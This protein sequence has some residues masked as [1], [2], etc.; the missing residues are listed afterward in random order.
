MMENGMSHESYPEH[1]DIETASEEYASRFSGSVGRFFLDV[2]T[3]IILGLLKDFSGASVL[4]VG[5]GHAQL[6]VPL[7]ENGFQVTVTGSDDICRSRLDKMLPADSF[8][9]QTCD[10]LHLPFADR[11]F[12]IVVAV[13]LLPHVE[14]WQLLLA[15]MCRVAERS[16]IVD[17]PDRRSV[18]ILYDLLFDMKK[19]MEGNTRTF[20]M[21]SR[22][23]LTMEFSK[24]DFRHPLFRPEFFIPM[25]VHRKLKIPAVSTGMEF[26]CRLTGLTRFL[27]SPI[28]LRSDRAD[29]NSAGRDGAAGK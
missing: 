3:R 24:N 15:E 13:R 12:D 17:Y 23:E 1:A 14:Q 29:I 21:F 18:N 5:G 4:D 26:L 6:A 20:S 19:K 27:G 10:S 25:V 8:N 2:Q 11:Q 22:S 28:V 9:Y 7:V 16:V